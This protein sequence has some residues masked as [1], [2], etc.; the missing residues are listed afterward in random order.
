[1]RACVRE[2]DLVTRFGG[3]EFVIVLPRINDGVDASRVATKLIETVG[4]PHRVGG[5][6]HHLGCSIGIS[7]FPDDAQTVDRLLRNADSAMFGAKEAGRGRYLFFDAAVNRAA[8][9]RTELERDIRRALA[10]VE[11][12]VA[13]QP[14]IDL[15]TSAIDGVEALVRWHHPSRG[16]VSPAEFIGVAERAGLITQIGEFV[17]RTACA[18]FA[19]WLEQGIAPRRIAVNVS[20]LE[21]T[22]SDIVTRVEAVLRDTG[23]RPMHLELELTEGILL[24]HAEATLEKLRLLRERGVR[25]ALDDFGTGYSSLSYLQRLPIDVLKIDQSF[26]RELSHSPDTRPIVRAILDVAHSLGKVV[27]AEGIETEQQLLLLSDWGCD[28]GQGYRW[29]RPLGATEFGA[30]CRQWR[31]AGQPVV[32][33]D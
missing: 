21:I 5:D 20:G 28:V 25:I 22:R 31:S 19:T 24:G 1:M 4:A 9:D 6:E 30:F 14:Q 3:D 12:T 33:E 15:R 23:L 26:V 18:Q 2:E 32:R 27:V 10:G 16:L 11:F 13:Y 17:M 29:S 7:I 8:A